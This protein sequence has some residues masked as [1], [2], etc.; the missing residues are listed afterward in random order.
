[1]NA[2]FFLGAK[3]A[4]SKDLENVLVHNLPSDLFFMQCVCGCVSFRLCVVAVAFSK[5]NI[6]TV[7]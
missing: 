1:M 2:I 6:I 7:G 4:P 5:A 3:F